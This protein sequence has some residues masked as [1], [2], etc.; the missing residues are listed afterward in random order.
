MF[1]SQYDICGVCLRCARAIDASG[2]RLDNRSQHLVLNLLVSLKVNDVDRRI[3][4]DDDLKN[5]APWAYDNRFKK[6]AVGQLLCRRIDFRCRN[7]LTSRDTRV[8][9]DRGIIDTL[10]SVDIETV[11]LIGLCVGLLRVDAGDQHNCQDNR[12]NRLCQNFYM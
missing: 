9:K 8:G 6:A 11:N 10:I 4:N 3:L 12:G 7:D 1:I 5:R 2:L